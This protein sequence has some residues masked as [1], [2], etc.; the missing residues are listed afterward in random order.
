MAD[1]QQVLENTVRRCRER[2]IIIP[3]LPADGEP[4]ADPGADPRRAQ[5]DRDAGP[6][7]PQPVPDH[8]EERAGGARRRLRRGQLHR[9]AAG[10]DRDPG[11]DPHAGGQ[12]FPTG[13]HKVGA[14]FGPLVEKLVRGAFD[15]T[16]QKALWPSTGNYCR[17]GAYNS[18]LL[19]CPAI[20][21]LPEGMSRERFD[22]LAEPRRRGLRHA[23]LGEQRQGG[24]RQDPR[25]QGGA[26]GR[27]GGLEPVR[28]VRERGLALRLHRPGHGRGLP[29]RAEVGPAPGRGV[30]DPGLGRHPRAAPSTCAS[31]YPRIKRRRGR[32]AAVPDPALATATAPT[33]SRGSA[34][35]TCRGSERE[36]HRR[37]GRDRRRGLHVPAAAVQ[38]AGGAGVP[39]A[40]RCRPRAG[41]AGSTCSASRA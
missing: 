25:A 38:R 24:L 41:R 10:A 6:P 13:A 23:G 30:P 36:E 4:R 12:Y 11:A 27:G 29:G 37:R 20:A 8:L 3:D 16:R 32:G 33:A 2:D 9:A 31:A 19:A 34:T 22:W 14:T 18:Y 40:P 15:P 28:G 21:V 1:V 17:G 35:S 7:P 26:A 5:R 39:G